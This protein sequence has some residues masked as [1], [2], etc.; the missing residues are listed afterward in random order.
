M[1]EPKPYAR[2]LDRIML[3]LSV[4]VIM[5]I[6]DA[7][8]PI[9][10]ELSN[11]T[12]LTNGAASSLIFSSF[13]IG[14]LL[15][16]IPFGVLS[17]SYG[18]RLFIIIGII[19]TLIS[20]LAIIISDDIWIIIIARFMEG[21]GC[22]AFFP[23]AL[24]MLS[25]FKKRGQYIGEFNSLLNLGLASGL[26]MAGILV[27]PTVIKNGVI[28]F[29]GLIIPVFM[30]SMMVLINNGR[31]DQTSRKSEFTLFLRKS[32]NVLSNKEYMPIWILSFILFGSGGV[33]IA[34]YS[35]YSADN[36]EKGMLG[37]YLASVYLG[38]M[39][40]SFVGG[41][42]SIGNDVLVKSGMLIT[43]VGTL[44]SIFHPL[45]LTL[46]GA[47]SGLGLVGLVTGVSYLKVEKGLIMGVFNTCTYAGLGI[48]PLISG[49][50]LSTLEYKGVFFIN[51]ILL[52]GMVFLPM[53]VLKKEK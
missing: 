8:V 51:G 5:G 1:T 24:S 6:S 12:A 15:T 47:G 14:A 21:A 48:V 53:K 2:T 7:I 18:N 32:G 13:F 45:G 39:T 26:L 17:D 44:V 34:L 25:Y 19:L 49:L 23:A 9:L 11:G 27:T 4:F 52:I 38:A 3:Y 20:G 40:T 16:M 35:D 29:E 43:G 30:I 41:R 22:G 10:P 36:L 31:G 28:L 50:M 46:M 37:T 42:L 33:L